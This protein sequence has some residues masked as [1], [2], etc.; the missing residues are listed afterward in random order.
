MA[1]NLLTDSLH[2][3]MSLSLIRIN[4]NMFAAGIQI[5]RTWK[6]A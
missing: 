5:Y 6:S 3:G 2:E 1:F 4:F